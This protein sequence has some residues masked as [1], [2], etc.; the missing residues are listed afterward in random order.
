MWEFWLRKNF[1]SELPHS[2]MA[3]VEYNIDYSNWEITLLK[4]VLKHAN[5]NQGPL[6]LKTGRNSTLRMLPNTSLHPESADSSVLYS[7]INK[8]SLA[9][10]HRKMKHKCVHT[11][12]PPASLHWSNSVLGAS[13]VCAELRVFPVHTLSP[14]SRS[15]CVA[16][17]ICGE[18]KK[19]TGFIP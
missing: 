17:G 19:G 3:F 16:A 15:L 18:V 9:D 10:H 12:T 13:A 2:W 4:S 7:M 11:L 14:C 1:R 5:Q 6:I 8:P